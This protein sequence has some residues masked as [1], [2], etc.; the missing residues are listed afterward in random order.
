MRLDTRRPGTSTTFI[1][2][3]SGEHILQVACDEG[4]L[5]FMA[6]HLYD[7]SGALVAES[8]GLEHVP[9]GLAIESDSGEMLLN[10]PLEITGDIQ[11]RLY[12]NSGRLLTSSDGARTMIYPHLRMEGVGRLWTHRA[13][14]VPPSKRI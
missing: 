1:D 13:E 9:L 11:Y 3:A 12:A 14:A 10:I 5:F 7:D 2:A 6:Y 8:P 4:G